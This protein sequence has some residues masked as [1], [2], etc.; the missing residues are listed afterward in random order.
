VEQIFIWKKQ[1]HSFNSRVG[2]GTPSPL[3]VR[4]AARA[5]VAAKA[6]GLLAGTIPALVATKPPLVLAAAAAVSRIASVMLAFILPVGAAA[7]TVAAS[8]SD[9]VLILPQFRRSFH[10]ELLWV[11]FPFPPPPDQ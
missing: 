10:E 7:P 2:W 9:P 1:A 4:L 6:A 11:C 8:P 5:V 3:H